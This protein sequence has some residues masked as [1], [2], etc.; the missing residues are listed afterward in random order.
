MSL[1]FLFC[2]DS[3][4]AS[5][6]TQSGEAFVLRSPSEYT[7]L[8]LSA[9]NVVKPK[10]FIE[11]APD[12]RPPLQLGPRMIDSVMNGEDRGHVSQT[13]YMSFIVHFYS[14]LAWYVVGRVSWNR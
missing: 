10:C 5:L 11:L 2:F 14:F 13:G 6:F 12:S 8:S 1:C 4:N 7:R 3:L 9:R